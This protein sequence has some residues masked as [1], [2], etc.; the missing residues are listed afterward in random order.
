M[1]PEALSA[2]TLLGPYLPIALVYVIGLPALSVSRLGLALWHSQRVKLTAISRLRFYLLG[3]RADIIQISLLCTPLVVLTPLLANELTWSLFIWLSYGWILLCL[4]LVIFMEIS[5]PSF[6]IQYDVRPNRLFIEY[7]KSPKEVFSTL[8]NG[9]RIPLILVVGATIILVVIAAWTLSFWLSATPT[10]SLWKIWLIAP[11]IGFFIF[12]GI[13]ST[14]DHRAANPALFAVTEDSLVNSLV[15]N[16]SWSVFHAIYNLRHEAKSSNVYG[17]LSTEEILKAT[18]QWIDCEIAQS[19][20]PLNKEHKATRRRKK[21]LNLVIIIEESLGAT[22]VES[23]GGRAT[24]PN[25]EKLKNEGWW[26]ENLYATGTRSVRGIEAVVSSFL[27]TPARSVV[28]LSLSQNNF[29]TIAKHLKHQGYISEFIYGGE[30]H[31]DNMQLFFTGNGF[32]SVVDQNDYKDPVFKGTWGVS[33]E[34]LFSKTDERLSQHH[35]DGTSFFSLVFTS[36]NH[37]P[38]EYPD[39]RIELYDEDPA[40]ENNAVKYA[41]HALG[42]FIENAKKQAYWEDTLFLVVADH[43]IRVRGDELVPIKHYQIPG[44]ILG[45]D[46]QPRTIKTVASQVDLPTTLLSLMGIDGAHPMVGRD[47]SAHSDDEAGRSFMQ[48]G[49]NYCML[50]GDRAVILRPGKNATF[51]VYNK[52]TQTLQTSEE[53]D[54]AMAER[55]LAYALLPSWLYRNQLYH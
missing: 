21:P 50:E 14:A 37:S 54:E 35:R 55:A 45:A 39:N 19:N 31:F 33:D 26:F 30:G 28:K 44:L 42:E 20:N 18:K 8:W 49:D 4:L 53:V 48:Y 11:I 13:R 5:T 47:L 51:A 3:I 16:S 10:W 25:L 29:F 27:P 36:S 22:F 23:L 15:I 2:S 17:S 9:F 38:F 24:S 1:L 32:D 34:D 43:D 46:I 52:E 7:L 40:T 12:A 6:I 41:D